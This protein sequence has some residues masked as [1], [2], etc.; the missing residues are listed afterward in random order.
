MHNIGLTRSRKLIEHST[1]LS[2][3]ADVPY[4]FC[5]MRFVRAKRTTITAMR[6]TATQRP[7]KGGPKGILLDVHFCLLEYPD[8]RKHFCWCVERGWW[9]PHAYEKMKAWAP[10]TPPLTHTH[11]PKEETCLNPFL[12]VPF[13]NFVL[14]V[15]GSCFSLLTNTRT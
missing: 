10:I 8:G 13:L 3:T 15:E 11:I 2:D 12:L 14:F 5:Q 4:A 6:F 9:H 1:V 7:A